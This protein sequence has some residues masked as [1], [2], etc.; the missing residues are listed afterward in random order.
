MP[1]D[2]TKIVATDWNAAPATYDFG[3]QTVLPGWND[4]HVIRTRS[5]SGRRPLDGGPG[6]DI[7]AGCRLK[8][9]KH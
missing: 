4:A 8:G 5:R 7:T 6:S 1:D 3:G 2:G 9:V